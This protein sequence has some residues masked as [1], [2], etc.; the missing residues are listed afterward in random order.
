MLKKIIPLFLSL[1][2]VTVTIN[3]A[4]EGMWPLDALKQLPWDKMTAQGLKLSPE[5]IYNPKGVSLADAI[6]QVGGGT[7]SFVSANGLIIT[8]HH[9]AFG[10][11]Q[12]Q[13]SAEQDFI[14]NG[15]LAKT[16]SD[17]IPAKGYTARLCIGFEDVTLKVLKGITD[18]MSY[19]ERN[20]LIEKNSQA[21]VKKAEK[22]DYIRANVAN[23]LSG[24]KYYLF[25]Y[26]VIKDVRLVYAPPRSIGEYGG[27]I[28]NWMWPRHTGDFS[29][30]RAYVGPDGKPAD[31]S[32]QNVPYK[33]KKYLKISLD[34]IN[35][36]DFT[37]VI[38][39]PGNTLRYRSSYSVDVWQ[40]EIYPAQI[41]FSETSIKALEELSGDDRDLQIKYAS[42]IK[43]L[44]NGLKYTQGMMAGLKRTRL[45][46][47]KQK[48]EAEFSKFLQQ[49]PVLDKKY[50]H[51]L[52][53]IAKVYTELW[54]YN[55]K[56]TALGNLF[57]SSQLL[58]GANFIHR[59]SI[60]K[61]KKEKDREPGFSDRNIERT[62]KQLEI[63]R[64]QIDISSDKKL[65]T[66]MIDKAAD[67]PE[68]QKIEAIQKFI[69][70]KTGKER[71]EAANKF[72]EDIFSRTIFTDFDKAMELFD[73]SEAEINQLNDPLIQF[74]AE[75]QKENKAIQDR[76]DAF[77]GAV[78]KLRPQLI[79]GMYEWKKGSLYPDANGTIRFTYGY[80]KGYQPRDAVKYNWITTLKGVIEKD[81][82]EEPFDNPKA[83]IDLFNNKNFGQYFDQNING[84]PVNFLHTTDITGG[85]S[86][87]PVLNGKGEIIGLVFDGNYEAM[88][89]DFVY[90]PDL[91]RSISV[92]IR[93]VLFIT[94]KLG[95]A[96]NVMKELG[97]VGSSY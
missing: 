73:K 32:D 61:Q 60:E 55:H 63:G 26:F 89:S 40:N 29:F 92:D 42:R 62:K 71:K 76:Y 83:L 37:M 85:N 28:D 70:T 53:E 58:N 51:V 54:T 90:D 34:G 38:G 93:Y 18:K 25:T 5:D 12:R 9:V 82:G 50:G 86:G 81:T 59:W 88:T 15:F 57:G 67:L 84:V 96:A 2:F 7:G 87:S 3:F 22:D 14:R 94:E 49:N 52:P 8:N 97:I 31:Y 56:Q 33:P 68:E 45:L 23:M 79:Q 6:I 47:K 1:I 19:S 66:I 20:D 78:Y 27:D 69:G 30:L 80:V 4:D 95:K 64:D 74:A 16:F 10:A 21:L 11:I 39:Y 35:K 72:V 75:L 46:E 24:T 77:A 41:D 91:T 36:D 43:G 44:N 65:L 13:S 48:Q 17:E